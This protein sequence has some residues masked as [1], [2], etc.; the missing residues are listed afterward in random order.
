MDGRRVLGVGKGREATD[1]QV[2][3]FSHALRALTADIGP[4][5]LGR[6]LGRSKQYVGQVRN[7]LV[8][9]PRALVF[10]LER[11]LEQPPGSLSRLLGYLPALTEV[12]GTEVAIM[13]DPLLSSDQRARLLDA[14][15]TAVNLSSGRDR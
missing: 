1:E 7:G 9:P 3:A 12:V 8:E 4:S 6:T 14:Y 5:N 10:E 15:R 13:R 2:A 11:V